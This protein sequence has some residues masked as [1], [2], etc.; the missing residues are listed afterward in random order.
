VTFVH[1]GDDEALLRA[2]REATC[3]VL[4]SVYRDMYGGHTHVPEL[5]G[6]TVLEGMACGAPGICSDVASL[7]E[8]VDPGATGFIVPANDPAA[9]MQ[10]LQT[11]AD[12]PGRARAMGAAARRSVVDRFTWAAVVDRCLHYYG[13]QAE[14]AQAAA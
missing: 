1:G 4:P 12:D 9:L 8:L 14:R 13:R 2:Y 11:L 10:R 5:L 7:P 6:Q 3:V